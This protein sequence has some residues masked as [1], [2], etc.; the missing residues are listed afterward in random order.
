MAVRLA[1]GSQL[2][3]RPMVASVVSSL[4]WPKR[5]PG[6]Y[7]ATAEKTIGS[8]ALLGRDGERSLTDT[9]SSRWAHGRIIVHRIGAILKGIADLHTEV[10]A[11]G[12][13]RRDIDPLRGLV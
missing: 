13:D 7:G 9:R 2:H 5:G 4:L 8:L 3:P 1:C 11:W 6:F 10:A 12:I